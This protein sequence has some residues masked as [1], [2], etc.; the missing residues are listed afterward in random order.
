MSRNKQKR[1]AIY[2]PASFSY[3]PSEVKQEI[4]DFFQWIWDTTNV[5]EKY[6]KANPSKA[7]RVK[8]ILGSW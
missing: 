6:E 8:E 3:K 7:K 1:L 4:D 2:V 5:T